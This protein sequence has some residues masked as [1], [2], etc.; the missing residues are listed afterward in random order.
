MPKPSG[1]AWPCKLMK[2]VGC[3][4]RLRRERERERESVCVCVRA[5]VR[6]RC[7]S[8]CVRA[9]TRHACALA[10]V[11]TGGGRVSTTT[12]ARSGFAYMH[13]ARTHACL[14]ASMHVSLVDRQGARSRVYS[15]SSDTHLHPRL[16]SC[17]NICVSYLGSKTETFTPGSILTT[18]GRASGPSPV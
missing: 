4:T 8:E 11:V 9:D 1:T 6:V 10:H 7:A 17:C 12:S 14:P 5:C 13:G 16:L 2:C 3:K 18:T 15:H